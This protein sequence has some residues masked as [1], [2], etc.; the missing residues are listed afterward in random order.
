MHLILLMNPSEI[1]T[2]IIACCYLLDLGRCYSPPNPINHCW[3]LYFQIDV[4]IQDEDLRTRKFFHPVSFSRVIRECE[5]RLVEDY[6][7]YLKAECQ[8]MI[9]DENRTGSFIGMS[10]A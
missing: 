2:D 7:P 8:Q 9:K 5:A 4:R 10:L 6:I 1:H 3:L